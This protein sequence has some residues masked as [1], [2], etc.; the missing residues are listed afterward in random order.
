MKTNTKLQNLVL[1]FALYVFNVTATATRT[2]NVEIL[3]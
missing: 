3:R 2:V 1:F